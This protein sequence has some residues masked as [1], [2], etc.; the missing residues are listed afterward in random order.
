MR[1]DRW[2]RNVVEASDRDPASHPSIASNLDRRVF[3]QQSHCVERSTASKITTVYWTHPSHPQGR[4]LYCLQS[5][6]ARVHFRNPS[7]GRHNINSL[8]HLPLDVFSCASAQQ[9]ATLLAP[10]SVH[11]FTHRRRQLHSFSRPAAIR[12]LA[13]TSNCIDLHAITGTIPSVF[14]HV[15]EWQ[16]LCL[17]NRLRLSLPL[18]QRTQ[19]WSPS[20]QNQCSHVLY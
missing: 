20:S 3:S 14:S 18:N 12:S 2:I 11:S 17:K 1:A 13:I 8:L 19:Q 4:T 6:Y 9:R 10:E 16:T 15:P 7:S 5:G